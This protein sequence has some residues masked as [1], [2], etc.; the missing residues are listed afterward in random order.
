MNQLY[1]YIYLLFFFYDSFSIKVIAEYWPEFLVLYSR[2]LLVIYFTYSSVYMSIPV[3]QFIPNPLLPL[4]SLSY[5]FNICDSV[6]IFFSIFNLNI[7]NLFTKLCWFLPSC[8]LSCFSCVWLF[9]T[10]W[11]V[12]HQASLSMGFSRW[13]YWSGLLCPPPEDLPY[14]RIEPASYVSCIG[15]RALYH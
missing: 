7:K 10:L 13:E 15:R 6:C 12:V 5:F 3:S 9:E 4:V 2:S 14:Q 8:L 11:T 1:V